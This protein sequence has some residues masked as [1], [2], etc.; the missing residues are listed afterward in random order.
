M[1]ILY[2]EGKTCIS[3]IGEGRRMHRRI[4]CESNE[5]KER[6]GLRAYSL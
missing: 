2:F 6:G 4:Y 5:G 3:T 1:G